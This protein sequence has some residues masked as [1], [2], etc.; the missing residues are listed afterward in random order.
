[1]TDTQSLSAI[2][3]DQVAT[4]PADDGSIHGLINS[5]LTPEPAMTSEVDAGAGEVNGTPTGG[6]GIAA[7]TNPDGSAKEAPT[8]QVP[9]TDNPDQ[10]LSPEEIQELR[11][12]AAAGHQLQTHLVQTVQAGRQQQQALAR[13]QALQATKE[14]VRSELIRLTGGDPDDEEIRQR[15]DA[16][17]AKIENG[18]HSQYQPLVNQ[19]EKR[20][21]EVSKNLYIM[22]QVIQDQVPEEQ[23]QQFRQ[24][25]ERLMVL[26]SSDAVNTVLEDKRNLR[27]AQTA[28]EAELQGQL[29]AANQRLAALGAINSGAYRAESGPTRNAA[30]P[31]SDDGSVAWLSAN[32]DRMPQVAT[33]RSDY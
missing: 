6:N 27:A 17:I 4:P 32:A 14:S 15:G 33:S 12:Q 1:M 24:E 16:L 8:G 7:E 2:L 19:A 10:P 18:L 5:L 3:P 11:K 23:F 20:Y 31:S 13:Q 9:G 22:F 29:D 25:V 30:P 21:E 26:E 28:R